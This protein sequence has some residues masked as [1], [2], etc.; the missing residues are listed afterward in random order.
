MEDQ[1][2]IECHVC[3]MDHTLRLEN[4]KFL[5]LAKLNEDAIRTTE[6]ENELSEI[7]KR[8]HLLEALMIPK[9]ET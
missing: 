1:S 8:L 3:A 2:P 7:R 9:A 6:L 4:W 5:L